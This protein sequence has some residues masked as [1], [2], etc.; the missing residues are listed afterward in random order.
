MRRFT[1][2]LIAA[3]VITLAACQADLSHIQGPA[4]RGA[5]VGGDTVVEQGFP[6]RPE[7]WEKATLDDE[8]D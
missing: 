1:G 8:D 2:I 7:L 4:D 6:D 5:A 3:L